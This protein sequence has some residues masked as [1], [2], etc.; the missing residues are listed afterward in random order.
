MA[1][2][3]AILQGII[4]DK[5]TKDRMPGATIVIKGTTMGAISDLDGQ[6]LIRNAPSG[7]QT[8]V[9][10]YIGYTQISIVLDI[11]K[12]GTIKHDFSL[13]ITTIRGK[14]IV[15][16]A[17][18]SGQASA[19]QQQLSSNKIVNVVSEAKIQELPD[20]NAAQAI[21]RLPGVSTLQSSGEA[22]KIVIRGLAPQ[23]NEV[24]IG[25]MTLAS[26]GNTSIGATSQG[27]TSGAL[28]QDRSVDLS[29]VTPYM[30][31]SIEV[32]KALTPDM[33]ANAIGG[34][35]NM[36]LRE[37]PSS[38]HGDILWQSG[39][40]QK[41]GTYGNYR[42]VASGSDRFFDDN[43]GVYA[44]VNAESYDRNADNMSASYNITNHIIGSNG[45]EPVSVANISLN[46]HFETRKRYGGNLIL[47]YKL[48]SGSIKM[49][50]MFS[51]LKS[52]YQDNT[53]T[54]DYVGRNLGFSYRAGDNTTDI[55]INSLDFTN[56]F[57]FMSVDL[58]AANTYSFNQLPNSPFFQFSQ[59][60]S[61]GSSAPV[62]TTPENLTNLVNYIGKGGDKSTYLTS[63][64]LFNAMYKENNQDYKGDFKI[65]YNIGSDLSGY[66]KLGGEYQYKDHRNSQNTPYANLNGTST[67]QN[68]MI[69]AIRARYPGLSYDSLAGKFAASNFT[70]TDS[71]I[72]ATF[73]GNSFGKFLWGAN[74]STLTDMANYISNSPQFNANLSSA[75][76]SGGWFDGYYQTLPNTY[77]YIEKYS[78][79]YLMSELEFYQLM[80]VGGVRYED[81]KSLFEAFNLEDGRDTQ[82]QTFYPVTIYPGNH[83]LL[84]MVQ[85][86]YG[87]ADWIDVR[88]A[89]TQTLARPDYTQLS[90]HFNMSYDKSQVWAGNPSLLPAQAYNNDVILTFHNNDVGL[91]SIGGFY[92]TIQ[93]FT[94][95]TQY[96]LHATSTSEDIQTISS[97]SIAGIS[98][99]D[100]AILYTFINSPYKALV[101]G[102]EADFQTRLW[103][104][105]APLDGIVCGVNYTHI[106]SSA[107]YP[108]RDDK[109]VFLPPPARGTY[110]VVIDSSRSG[111]LIN[112]P[113]DILN[114][115]VGWDYK[116]FS[117][118]LSFLFQGN[119]VSYIGA[120]AEQDGFTRNYFRTDASV[121][122]QLPLE[123]FE[124]YFD[125]NNIN[126]QMNS[127]AQSSIGGFTSEQNYGL[128]ADLGIRYR[129]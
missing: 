121:K 59:T 19:I 40:T 95:A 104:L 103:Y 99:K 5:T 9:I 50:N 35:V 24:A 56:D 117:V 31:K 21:S 10:S 74:S 107:T 71:K 78:S 64:S 15:V 67:I 82:H 129:L 39:Y 108:W 92:K 98:P 6:Y 28:S 22:N 33:N 2:G 126:N 12:E 127:S 48:P 81:E 7:R 112:Q 116:G 113:N 63:V 4:Y 45:Y 8:I 55:A 125:V 97:Y 18:A 23:Y 26:T 94:Y 52:D 14:E 114:A 91:L 51:R 73:L 77:K 128:T 25:G 16:T 124:V 37:A 38:L 65:P 20:F 85:A 3:S 32:Y 72:V 115:Y 119:S 60:G 93:K 30:I 88:Y 70:S 54:L 86:K 62:N 122:Q 29:M 46:R 41:S 79:A 76:N 87:F 47:D 43:F 120:F 49:I 44:L 83:Y 66:F 106:W 57:G 61:I 123:G 58:K 96:K 17:Q 109:T 84:P 36:E 1:Q 68:Q 105:P 90:P 118:R 89:Y 80:L 11:P 34:Y 75:A 69:N 42:L 110:T 111:R 13:E 102:I 101:K 27:G 100:G 53:M